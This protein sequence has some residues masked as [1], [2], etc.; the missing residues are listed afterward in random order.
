MGRIGFGKAL[1]QATESLLPCLHPFRMIRGQ[2]FLGPAPGEPANALRVAARCCGEQQFRILE[3]A[4]RGLGALAILR[5]NRHLQET[6]RAGDGLEGLAPEDGFRGFSGHGG[7]GR[8]AVRLSRGNRGQ[9]R[10][11][12][13]ADRFEVGPAR[14]FGDGA[15]RDEKPERPP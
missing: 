3:T 12:L 13:G 11:R 14:H 9:P 4:H 1:E 8:I 6:V 2:P 5:R 15:Q 10:E 7:E